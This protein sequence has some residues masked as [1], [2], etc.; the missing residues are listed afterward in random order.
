MIRS[1]KMDTYE[2]RIYCDYCDVELTFANTVLTKH[3]PL[4]VHRCP[5]CKRETEE[6]NSF[7]FTYHVY[8]SE[9]WYFTVLDW[10][11]RI[12]K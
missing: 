2:M 10:V 5:K 11:F 4:Y 6:K 7:P 1:T 3:P 12:K 9:P 8:A